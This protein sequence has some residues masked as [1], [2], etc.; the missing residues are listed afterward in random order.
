MNELE[1]I[2]ALDMATNQLTEI[3]GAITAGDYSVLQE[4]LLKQAVVLHNLGMSFIEKSNEATKLQY[5]IGC[6]D[7]ALRSLGQSQKTMLSIKMMKAEK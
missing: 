7:I 1:C 6:M 2:P 4:I 5:K 3:Q